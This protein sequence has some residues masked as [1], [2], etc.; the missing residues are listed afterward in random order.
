MAT[1]DDPMSPMNLSLPAIVGFRLSRALWLA[2]RLRVADA[3]GA[4]PMPVDDIADACGAHPASLKRLLNALAAA[5]LF[6]RDEHGCF[7]LTPAGEPLRSD[8]PRSQRAWLEVMLG[9][10]HYEA[11]GAMET[12]LRTGQTAFEARYGT[13]F[14]DYHRAHPAAGRAFAE[15]MGATTRAFED[16]VLDAD[17]FPEFDL[18][19]D[20]GGSHG[21]LLGR[22]LERRPQA[23]GVLFDVPEVIHDWRAQ[24]PN[25]LDGRITAVGG[26]FFRAVPGGGDLYLLKFIL[27]DWDDERAAAILRR[28]REAVAPRGALALVEMV[29]PEWP[30]EH[31]GWL[32]DLNMLAL[33]GGRERTESELATL[34]DQAGWRLER[35]AATASP[36]SVV[37]AVPA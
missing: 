21:S 10:E 5:G 7:A 32:M 11:W 35:T 17:P 31:P 2:A 3:M 19:V 22:L 28:V 36:L 34:L 24:A 1:R 30:T 23:R 15:A 6:E 9:G 8:H 20:V 16:A 37:V 27:H 25:D 4:G 18:A 12:S 26:D 13:P 29:L 14:F 33:T